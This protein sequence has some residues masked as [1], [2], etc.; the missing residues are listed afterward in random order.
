ALTDVGVLAA[1][2]AIYSRPLP[3]MVAARDAAMADLLLARLPTDTAAVVWAHDAHVGAGQLMGAPAMGQHLRRHLGPAYVAVGVGFGEG[4]FQAHRHQPDGRGPM[5]GFV[6]GPPPAELIEAELNTAPHDAF[7]LDLRALPAAARAP[8]EA[9]RPR[10]SLG[11]TY[12]PSWEHSAPPVP[13]AGSFDVVVH[14]KKVE[15]A[16]PLG[17]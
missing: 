2:C 6:L 16:H 5:T 3:E 12:D 14:L 10:R 4:G 13:L 11:A 17:R 8:F 15:R 9:P 1:H 7:L